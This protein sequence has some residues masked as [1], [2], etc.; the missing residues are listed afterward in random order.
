MSAY[1]IQKISQFVQ[2]KKALIFDDKRIYRHKTKLALLEL[3]LE[4]KNIF[5]E[6]SFQEAHHILE[7]HKPEIIV[8]EFQVFDNFG[9]DLAREQLNF[10]KLSNEKLFI[11]P[12]E[13]ASNASVADAAEEEVEA[14][15]LKPFDSKKILHYIRSATHRKLNPSPYSALINDIK[16]MIQNENYESARKSLNMAKIL[17]ERPM[18]ACYYLGEIHRKHKEY[19]KALDEFENGLS[20]NEYHYKCLLGKFLVYKEQNNKSKAFACLKKYLINFL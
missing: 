7:T 3:G 16:N 15:V 9:L 10:I 5:I 8:S 19:S 4:P 6:K 11:I 14:F 2:K 18:M 12:T 1:N 13:E 20:Y 17:S